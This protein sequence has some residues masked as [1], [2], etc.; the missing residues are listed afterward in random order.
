MEINKWFGNDKTRH[1]NSS[2]T[3]A[4]SREGKLPDLQVIVIGDSTVA[5]YPAGGAMRGWGQMLPGVLEP[6][7]LPDICSELADKGLR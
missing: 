4:Q 6:L 1:R 3:K 7:D 5:D 2:H